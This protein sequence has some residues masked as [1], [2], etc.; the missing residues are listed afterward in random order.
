MAPLEGAILSKHSFAALQPKPQLSL[1]LEGKVPSKA[2]RMR[3]HSALSVSPA[4][5]SSPKG[6]AKAHTHGTESPSPTPVSINRTVGERFAS[7]TR[8]TPNAFSLRACLQ[9]K[10]HLSLPLEGKLPG[11]ARQKKCRREHSPKWSF[12]YRCA[13]I[14]LQPRSTAEFGKMA[15]YIV[16]QGLGPA[17]LMAPS[18]RGLSRRSRDWGSF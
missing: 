9:P 3:C 7:R 5:D 14:H 2:R 18:P 13:A 8:N 15:D 10:P 4:L 12:S 17:V 16:G 11:E 6:R 1:P